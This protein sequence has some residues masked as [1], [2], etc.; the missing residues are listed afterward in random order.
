MEL[1][2]EGPLVAPGTVSS[3]SLAALIA[4]MTFLCALLWG[5]VVLVERAA[6]AWGAS[7]LGEI[8]VTVLPVEGESIEARVAAA[9]AILETEAG[10]SEV[11]VVSPRESEALLEPWLGTG[12]DLS[13]LPVPRL[14]TAKSEGR[15]NGAALASRLAA[16]P[17]VSLDDHTGWSARLSAMAG[18]VAGGTVAALLLMMM[19]TVL[20]VVFATRAAISS[21]AATVEVLH[22]LGA[23]RHFV[24]R[25]FRRRFWRIALAGAALGAGAA[26]ALFAGLSLFGMLA[27]GAQTAQA[28]ALFGNPDIGL[29]GFV[30]IAAIAVAIV[31]LTALASDRAVRRHLKDQEI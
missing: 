12:L 16:V 19:A 17:D 21:N 23:D 20:S 31:V 28:R 3:R 4:I 7:V 11:T 24:A 14:I 30:G 5:G 8:T 18:R 25:A 27:A 22:L 13:L 15:L 6:G 9:V 10:L 29:G 26:A 1:P 2:E